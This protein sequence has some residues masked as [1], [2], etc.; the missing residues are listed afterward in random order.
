M[1]ASL[2]TAILSRDLDAL[3]G[4]C[5]RDLDAAVARAG[6]GGHDL[7]VVDNAS[8]TP[9]PASLPGCPQYRH[10]RLDVHHGFAE[11]CNIAVAGADTDF[12]LFL[13]NDV[14]LDPEALESML[15]AFARHP[16]LGICGTRML[17]PDGTVQHAGVVMAPAP[18]G[19]YH[20]GR[21]ARP[22]CVSRMRE[23]FQAVTGACLMIT[24]QAFEAVDGFEASYNFGYEDV[25]LCLKVR[26]HGWD[27]R[28]VQDTASL[29]FEAMTPGRSDFAVASLQHF[30]SLWAGRYTIDG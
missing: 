22:E 26:Q 20:I 24:R 5:L 18:K 1:T 11:A 4:R 28:C 12:L 19:P 6:F 10:L 7:V 14:L 21:R 2:T 13:N 30:L 23:R 29:H 3:L 16:D 8:T 27:V 9:L 17:F 25:D 15:A